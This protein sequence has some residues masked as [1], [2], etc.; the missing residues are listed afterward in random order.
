MAKQLVKILTDLPADGITSYVCEKVDGTLEVIG[1]VTIMEDG[2]AVVMNE[3][4][5]LQFFDT[6]EDAL[7]YIE[8]RMSLEPVYVR[9]V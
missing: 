2:R 3:W 6:K 1:D 7:W 5:G 8:G 9:K 4:S